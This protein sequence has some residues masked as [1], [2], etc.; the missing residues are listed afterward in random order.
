MAATTLALPSALTLREAK[1]ASAALTAAVLQQPAQCAVHV[2]ASSLQKFDSAALAVLLE[3]RRVA[4]GSG[5]SFGV[6]G[7]PESLQGLARVYGV[8]ALLV[9]HVA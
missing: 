1:A 3:C 7:L 5:R 6:H 9:P 4:L 2:N 8:E